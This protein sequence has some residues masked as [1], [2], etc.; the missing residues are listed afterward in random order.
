[1]QS[2]SIFP[3]TATEPNTTFG[4][5]TQLQVQ[6]EAYHRIQLEQDK[7]YAKSD[8]PDL[9]S[10]WR[11]KVLE[12]M[13]QHKFEILAKDKRISDLEANFETV[14]TEQNTRIQELQA[15]V[16]MLVKKQKDERL[17]FDTIISANQDQISKLQQKCRAQTSQLQTVGQ[18]LKR[19]FFTKFIESKHFIAEWTRYRIYFY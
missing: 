16:D 13:V 3:P 1:M 10:R 5:I 17:E 9:L 7:L 8:N 15:K 6:L 12:L 14:T 2:H 11:K 4:S 18:L 19:Y